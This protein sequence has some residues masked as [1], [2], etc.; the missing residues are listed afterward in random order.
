[1]IPP[2]RLFA[3]TG[4]AIACIAGR[5]GERL[6]FELALT[7]SGAQCVAV[8]P[9]DPGRIYA[10]TLDD[11]MYRSLDAGTSW[12][13]V[14]ASIPERR[15]L[16]IEISPSHRV[17]GR[18]V[19]YAGTEPSGLYRSEDD[20]RSWQALSSLRELPSAS[21]W[22]FPP[23]PWTSHVRWIATHPSDPGLLFVGIELGGVMCSRDGGETW[24]DRRPDSYPDCHALA[25]HPLAPE[26]VYEASGQGVALSTDAGR[27]WRRLDD[28]M[29]RH[30]A[31][32]L[33]VDTAD[34]DLWY[35]S[36]SSGP[37]AAHRGDRDAEAVIYRKRGEEPWQA[38]DRAEGLPHPLAQM[39]YALLAPRYRPG[40][41]IAGLGDGELLLTEDA[42]ESWRKLEVRLPGLLALSQAAI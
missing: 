9:H 23:R 40:T 12:N 11:G 27:S 13:Q 24:E 42:G 41:L 30:Y 1:M 32:G 26:R 36:A 20:G 25:T 22:S 38:L 5:D 31:W 37:A 33:A 2:V 7:G 3:A 14:G 21:S 4:D 34:P 19:V 15:V 8:D 39:P 35:V 17:D 10:G 16:S 28:G 6:G 18:P 29:D